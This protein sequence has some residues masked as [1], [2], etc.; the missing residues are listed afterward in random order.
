MMSLLCCDVTTSTWKLSDFTGIAQIIIAGTNL[1]LASYV[2][3]Y[4]IRKDKK[5]NNDTARLHEQNI[6]LQWFKEL[7]VQPNMLA[8]ETFYAN[9][10][11]INAKINSNDLTVEEKEDINNFAKA[12][13]SKLRKSFIDALQLVD[14]KFGD[15]LLSNLDELIDS[16]TNAIFNE[17][18]KLKLPTVYEKHINS[19]ISYSKNNLI[20]QLFNYKGL[21]S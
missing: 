2:L 19:K 16:I 20:A 18:L 21:S 8:I 7:I 6:K 12:E 9:L 4:Q 11:T 17:E 3:F 10:Y 14:K 5:T 15:Q 1:F 13:L